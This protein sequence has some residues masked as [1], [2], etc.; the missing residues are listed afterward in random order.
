MSLD[1]KR[2]FAEAQTAIRS[3]N[4][5]IA[6]LEEELANKITE[7]ER[8]AKIYNAIAP[9]VNQP[10]IP[11]IADAKMPPPQI[12]LI[13]DAGI[14]V[15]IRAVLDAYPDENFTAA[16]MR[17]RLEKHQWSWEDYKNPLSSVHTT[18]VRLIKSEHAKEAA[19]PEGTKAFYSAKRQQK[20]KPPVEYWAAKLGPLTPAAVV[21]PDVITASV[22][23]D[24]AAHEAILSTIKDYQRLLEPY[25]SSL[26]SLPSIAPFSAEPEVT[27]PLGGLVGGLAEPSK[28]KKP[29][30]KK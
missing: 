21:V 7:R 1:F 13:Q 28:S 10:R 8:V 30:G 27:G 6:N 20:Q 19:T 18:L 5:D 12:E 22:A 16:Q 26:A 11:T 29:E 17:D 2:M 25:Y 4:A 9:T 3:V 14:S 15:A 24:K 23:R